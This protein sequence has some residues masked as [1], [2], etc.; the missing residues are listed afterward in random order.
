MSREVANLVEYCG[1]ELAYQKITIEPRAVRHH[2]GDESDS[3]GF[4]PDLRL[5]QSKCRTL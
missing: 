4:I 3:F 1:M 2:F 5:T